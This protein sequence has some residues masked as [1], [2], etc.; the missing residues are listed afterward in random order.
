MNKQYF[1]IGLVFVVLL[2]LSITIKPNLRQRDVTRIVE[3]VLTHWE[4]GDI[5]MA[6]SYWERAVD[7]PPV[8]GLT[9]YEI[10]DGKVIKKNGIFS[11]QVTATLDFSPNNTFP[12]GKKWI[13]DLN[14]TRYGWKIIDFHLL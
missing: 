5:P 14:K 12:S 10:N 2:I 13:F 6:M 1:V 11:A 3:T 4:N 8:F 9:A 7:S